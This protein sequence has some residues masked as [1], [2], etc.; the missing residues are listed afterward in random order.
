VFEASFRLSNELWRAIDT[1]HDARI[2]A[3]A[4]LDAKDKKRNVKAAIGRYIDIGNKLFRSCGGNDGN[5]L[6]KKEPAEAW[7]TDSHRFVIAAFGSGEGELLLSDV[8]YTFYSGDGLV[9]NWVK[10][11]I[12]RLTELIVRVDSLDVDRAF[13]PVSWPSS[14]LNKVD[15]A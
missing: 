12:K 7:V 4:E 3:E 11:R 8:G 13:D 2:K 1:E 14:Q 15:G 9:G 6:H 5:D 10:G